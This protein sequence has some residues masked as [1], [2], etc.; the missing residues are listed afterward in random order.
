MAL[1]E[2]QIR[3]MRAKAG[4]PEGGFARAMELPNST[5][6]L[7]GVT[8][9]EDI[10]TTADDRIRKLRTAAG[11]SE[12]IE[13]TPAP[14]IEEGLDGPPLLGFGPPGMGGTRTKKLVKDI[15]G[16]F[17]KRGERVVDDWSELF[18]GQIEAPEVGMRTASELFG[19]INDIIGRSIG[20]A[21]SAVNDATGGK[22]GDE[23]KKLADTSLGRAALGALAKG[24]EAWGEFETKYPRVAKDLMIIPQG[25]TL[26]ANVVGAGAAKN[27]IQK[28]GEAA[29]PALKKAGESA[30]KTAVVAGER[31]AEVAKTGKKVASGLG[32]AATEHMTAMK[33][34]VFFDILKNPERY[35][36]EAMAG[37]SRQ[38]LGDLVH[39]EAVKK[40]EKLFGAAPKIDEVAHEIQ[41]AAAARI[42]KIREGSPKPEQLGEEVK[43]ALIKKKQA[44]NEHKKLYSTLGNDSRPGAPRAGIKVDPNWLK[45]QLQGVGVRIGDDGRI[46]AIDAMSPVSLS[47]SPSAASRLQALWDDWAP[48]FSKGAISRQEFMNFRETLAE[49]ANYKGGVDTQLEKVAHRF[50]DS[51]NKDYRPKIPGLEKLDV[52]HT[53]MIRDYDRLAKGNIIEDDLGQLQLQE[54]ALSRIINA[55]KDTKSG[56]AQQLED[57]VPGITK[58][59]K[60]IETADAETGRIAS[61][62]LDD[63]GNLTEAAMS[64]I[65]SATKEER[66]VLA[67]RL[68]EILPGVTAKI[69]KIQDTKDEVGRL[70]KGLVDDK[71]HL[72]EGAENKIANAGGI[73]K[74]IFVER[75][76]EIVP[77]IGEKIKF[78]R[79]V[80]SIRDA[81]GLKV[82]AYIR[83]GVAAS[84]AFSMN[85]WLIVAVAITH[86]SAAVPIMRG[87]GMSAK[88]ARE[89]IEGLG[90]KISGRAS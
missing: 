74:D 50:R 46:G 82:G 80:E 17:K 47:R 78:L 54:G 41:T 2:D 18:S 69:Q 49:V 56:T 68:E 22:L 79:N 59:V 85:P 37:A 64:K 6:E 81:A 27:G 61:G 13:P 4:I 90:M 10:M 58:K 63:R 9:V 3:E 76:E 53:N 86:P 75:L 35:S 88:K 65:M 52:E 8:H 12:N 20:A 25:A 31:A 36:D 87:L 39:T 67:D 21:A 44:I 32:S 42:G 71:G 34:E 57:L 51:L 24:A 70:T 73:G 55:T 89:F 11:M 14:E 84:A 15:A 62:L 26:V 19:G 45:R 29:L 7:T 5:K 33:P 72:M 77:G 1:S 28:T 83:G 48:R 23:M 16:D 30:A 43:A 60:D 40:T 66:A 38:H